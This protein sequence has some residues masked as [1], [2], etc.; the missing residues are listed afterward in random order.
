MLG[1]VRRGD[2]RCLAVAPP[3]RSID[4]PVGPIDAAALPGE[5]ALRA[6]WHDVLSAPDWQAA[7]AKVDGG[8]AVAAR[9]SNGRTCLAVDRFAIQTLCYRVVDG[10]LRFAANADTLAEAGADIDPQ[11]IF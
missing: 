7:L 1:R 11:A 8:F 4:R 2:R 3:A 6:A 5:P 9:D 10:E